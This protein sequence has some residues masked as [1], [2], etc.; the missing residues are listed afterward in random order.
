MQKTHTVCL[1]KKWISLLRK[2]VTFFDTVSWIIIFYVTCHLMY[3]DEKTADLPL[4]MQFK[5][6]YIFGICSDVRNLIHW[7]IGLSLLINLDDKGICNS[8]KFGLRKDCSYSSNGCL[9]R[10][11]NKK[12]SGK[13]QYGSGARSRTIN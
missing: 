4:L 2:I 3:T 7:L 11:S 9:W 1:K 10:C 8:G 13:I 12:C 6:K 5:L